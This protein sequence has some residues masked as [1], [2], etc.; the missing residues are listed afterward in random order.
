M[1]ST[2]LRAS[3]AHVIVIG[4]GRLGTVLTRALRTAG[5]RVDGPFGRDDADEAP[6]ADVAILCVPDAQIPAAARAVRERVRLIGH[7]S[8]ATTLGD[9]DFGIH[10]LQTFTGAEPPEVFHG[11]GCAVAGRTPQALGLAEGLAR[12]LGARPFRI[13]DAHRAAYHA[14]ASLASN[15]TLTVLDAAERL[16]GAAGIPAAEAR[17]LLTPLASRTLDNWTA[18]GAAAALT[19]PIARGDEQTVRRQRDA[20]AASMPALLPLFDELC[21]RTRTIAA[22]GASAASVPPR[23]PVP[24][25]EGVPA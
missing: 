23:E 7:V 21:D 14:A 3:E 4:A 22:A 5:V 13:D 11:I 12:L 17:T 10:P 2:P 15:F 24:P 18:Q 9:A 20:V 25:R 1:N 8:G 19:G 16:A 6:V